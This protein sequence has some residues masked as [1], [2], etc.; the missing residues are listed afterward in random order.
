MPSPASRRRRKSRAAKEG[1]GGAKGELKG[2]AADGGRRRRNSGNI[3][4]RRIGIC[5]VSLLWRL[6]SLFNRSY[7]VSQCGLAVAYFGVGISLAAS[8]INGGGIEND[9]ARR[10]T[11]ARRPS[12]HRREAGNRGR[13]PGRRLAASA[14]R[15]KYL[16]AS[17]NLRGG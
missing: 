5:G 2:R 7:S 12:S 15:S 17:R 4:L 8:A 14:S 11:G 10:R 16:Q 9:A 3:R 13:P 1:E 6:L